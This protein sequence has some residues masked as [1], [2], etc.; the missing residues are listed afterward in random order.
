MK[1]YT[2]HT[3]TEV[4]AM[5][6]AIKAASLDGLY[7]GFSHLFA[8]DIAVPNGK[9]QMETE[10]F[11]ADTAAKN[12]VY[13]S[14]FRGAG[15]Y[16]HYIPSAVKAIA[17]RPEFVTAYTPYQAE[18]SQGILQSIFEYQTMIANL[19]GMDVSN[20]SHYD[21]ST[22]TADGILMLR[23][24]NK[25]KVL[26]SAGMNPNTIEVI[27]TYL[28]PLDILV[29]IVALDEN[30]KTSISDIEKNIDENVFAVAIAQ[31]NY[32]GIIEDAK[33][34]GAFLHEKKIGYLMN[35][36]PFSQML[37]PSAGECLA[38]V[39]AG[40][41]QPLGLPLAFGGPYLGFLTTTQKNMR[42]MVGRIVGRTADDKG[43]TAYVLTLQAR[44]QHIRRDKASSSICS[45]EA[46]CA[47]TSAVY[48]S[49]M[50]RAGLAEAA[51]QCV[52]NAHY[53]AEK[54][55][56]SGLRRKYPSE[57][58]NEFVTV[59]DRKADDIIRLCEKK[60]I[61]AGQK[62]AEHEILWCATEVNTRQEIDFLARLIKEGF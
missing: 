13:K 31:P 57:F 52:D 35:V 10:R 53:L 26:V 32:F 49:V 54:L 5:L 4:S 23:E 45:N 61:L 55:A 41:G 58:F 6:D 40:E 21:G 1:G 20:A 17:A 25:N 16:S 11:F 42:K 37:L 27:R 60:G 14:I 19:T 47:L 24:R 3:E 7:E 15:A 43:N 9:S 33:G 2:P 12:R 56:E 34:I 36:E 46:H 22:A 38:S 8:R 59:S 29:Q 62:I 30:G 50:G 39:A 51:S 18:L 28:E 44:E 48:M